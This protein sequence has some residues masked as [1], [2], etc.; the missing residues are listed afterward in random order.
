MIINSVDFNPEEFCH[1]FLCQ[2]NCF[3]L[4]DR[5]Y[6]SRIIRKIIKNKLYFLCH[7][8]SS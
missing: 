5:L 2:E 7:S 8:I 1:G 6:R 3:I 4:N